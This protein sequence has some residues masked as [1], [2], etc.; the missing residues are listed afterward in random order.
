MEEFL[1]LLL[2]FVLGGLLVGWLT[3]SQLFSQQAHYQQ[4]I[5]QLSTEKQ[6]AQARLQDKE[7]QW[8]Q[9]QE[10]LQG[11]FRA[12]ASQIMEEKGKKIA[13]VNQMQVSLL[14]SPLQER[15]QEFQ[16][17]VEEVYDKE[18]KQRFALEKEIK[19][20]CQLN[21]QITKE[22]NNLATALRGQAKVRGNW[23]E[24]ILES[25]LEKSGLER[26]R[27]YQL[28]YSLSSEGKRVQPD[29][30]IFLPENKYFVIDAKVSLLAYEQY[31][32]AESEEQS[33]R[34]LREHLQAVRR[35]VEQLSE[36]N[37]P[38]AI[39]QGSP[40][41]VIMFMPIEGAFQL[42]IQHDHQLFSWA[43]ERQVIPVGASTL[44]ATLKTAFTIWRLEKQSKNAEEIAR[45]AGALYD[46][47]VN[48]VADL[49]KIG[50]QI[51]QVKDAYEQ[52]LNKLSTG[53]G[54][55]ISRAEK[56]R[57]LGAKTTKRFP[58]LLF[59]QTAEETEQQ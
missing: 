3:R 52:A 9:W 33:Q 5:A 26:N 8:Q 57:Q 15:L 41:F 46:K 39:G 50:A 17:K 44:M 24:M 35:H 54:N 20:L 29:A 51:E 59:D 18:S 4:Q 1:Y 23:G 58:P 55:L 31:L 28:Q 42:A 7:K 6:L 13:E 10:E 49:Q 2:G 27:E 36:K 56:I 34:Y 37:Y 16:R 25:I 11:Q 38:H 48:F 53:K 21:Q 40:D 45:Q 12:I 47:L 30:I 19:Q 32:S 22:A 43:F 14:L